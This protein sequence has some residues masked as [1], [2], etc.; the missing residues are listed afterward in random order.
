MEKVELVI[1][2]VEVF[3]S[4]FKRFI[5]A[6]VYIKGDR[7]YYIDTKREECLAAEKTV[8]GKGKF[9]IPGLVDIHMH[10]ESSMMTPG[11]FCR[12]L[13]SCG[14]TT[15]VAEPHEIANIK[16]IEGINHMIEAGKQSVIDVYYGIPSSVPSTN[17]NLET[18]GAKIDFESM[19]QLMQ[20][21]NVICV[22]EIMNYRQIIKENNLEI[23][24][25]LKYL[26]K[27]R[28]NYIIEGHCPSLV[29]LDLAKFLYLG[30]N[31]DHTEHSLEE[32]KQ[33]FANGMYVEIQE[34]VM[35][36]EILNYIIENNLYEHCGFVTDDTSAD[37]LYESG[38]L[39]M[40]VKEAIKLGFSC[41]N[42]IYCSTYTNARRMNLTDRGAIAPGKLADFIL[43][44]NVE[45]FRIASVYKNGREI[46]N[47]N[48]RVEEKN[49]DYIFPEDY[50]QSVFIKPLTRKD[51]IIPVKE[52]ADSVVVKA[53]K[54]A[55]G[56]TRTTIK[57]IEMPVVDHELKWEDTGCLLAAVLERH[58]KNGN[59]GL[60]LVTGDCLKHGA[61]AT[62]HCHDHHNLL[63]IGDSID[64]IM[65]A[66]NRV[67]E[68]QGGIVVVDKGKILGELQ[69]NVC[70]IMS[71]GSVK[72]IGL[73][74][75]HIKKC[76]EQLGYKHYNPIT[77]LCTLAL[78]VSPALKITDRGL[79]DVKKGCIVPLY[80]YKK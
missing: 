79:V 14:V 72:D 8:D 9:M 60:G 59:I 42:A 6:D 58:G 75:K 35:K 2:N 54:V 39:N 45:E 37:K 47:S 68:L 49:S 43:L 17:D 16:G 12:R 31:A 56:T 73:S 13:A 48:N 51:F 19:K 21:E 36:P 34:K 70:G 26:R 5:N 71:D 33:R 64:N 24:K 77:S 46:Y 66:I 11:P 29:D 28:P 27:N 44:D 3:N 62:T 61:V 65:Q 74:L 78:P 10:I 22:G 67:V 50:Y 20:C 69:L 63:V 80:E 76:L 53:I 18:T 32:I 4:Y 25:F 15:I 7:I 55:D 38:H 41:E 23:T 57:E 40:L 1:K 30:I 52:N